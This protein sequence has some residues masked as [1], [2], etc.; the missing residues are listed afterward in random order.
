[1]EAL[2]FNHSNVIDSS[3]LY[4]LENEPNAA[5]SVRDI[6]DQVLGVK[7]SDTHDSIMDARSALYA[8]AVILVSGPQRA[9]VRT[10]GNVS[11]SATQNGKNIGVFQLLVHRIPDF[12]SD[13]HITEMIVKYTG[14]VPVKVNPITRSATGGA[15]PDATSAAAGS[16]KTTVQFLSQM[17]AD[18][19]FDSIVGPNRPDKQGRDQKR[20]YLKGGGYICVRK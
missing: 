6:S 2:H 4:Q 14:I 5:A 10:S 16:G 8:A 13:E 17:H 9:L 19:A 1:L 15:T 12:C 20:I 11:S 3:Y 18:L 7:L